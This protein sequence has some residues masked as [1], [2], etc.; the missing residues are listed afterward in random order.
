VYFDFSTFSFQLPTIGSFD[1]AD[2][3][4]AASAK[5]A[6]AKATNALRNIALMDVSLVCDGSIPLT[7]SA[8]QYAHEPSRQIVDLSRGSNG[9]MGSIVLSAADAGVY[10]IIAGK[11]MTQQEP[12]GGGS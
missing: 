6:S 7:E 4:V 12:T 10:A 8:S 3:P 11:S 2:A 1:W 5:A 9:C